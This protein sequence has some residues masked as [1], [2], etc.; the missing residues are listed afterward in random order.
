MSDIIS[1]VR[2][3][4]VYLLKKKK[5]Q[6]KGN[7]YPELL[8]TASL[9]VGGMMKQMDGTVASFPLELLTFH[10]KGCELF[11]STHSSPLCTVIYNTWPTSAKYLNHPK[12]KT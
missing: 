3:L 9:L 11:N 7:L 10:L 8:S 5:I 12:I 2:E 6:T 4:Y 1:N